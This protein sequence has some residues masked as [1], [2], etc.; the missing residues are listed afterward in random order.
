M[1]L[2]MG[3][4]SLITALLVYPIT[5]GKIGRTEAQK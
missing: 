2:L 1:A 3:T 4:L 5:G